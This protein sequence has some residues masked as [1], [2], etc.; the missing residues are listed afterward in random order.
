M[1]SITRRAFTIEICSLPSS[2]HSAGPAAVD[3]VGD[4]M[5]SAIWHS[6]S[7]VSVPG[8]VAGPFSSQKGSFNILHPARQVTDVGCQVIRQDVRCRSNPVHGCLSERRKSQQ[9]G[10]LAQFHYRSKVHR[11]SPADTVA[12][13]QNHAPAVA[14]AAASAASPR[15]NV[16]AASASG[17]QSAPDQCGGFKPRQNRLPSPRRA[18]GCNPAGKTSQ[19]PLAAARRM[20]RNP[21]VRPAAKSAPLSLTPA[22][23]QPGPAKLPR[24]G[25]CMISSR[26]SG[27]EGFN[28]P[29]QQSA[30]PSRCSP[31]VRNCPYRQG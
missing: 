3:G 21:I 1:H 7:R 10:Q 9:Y 25:S 22:P 14:S 19:R 31:P 26:R 13:Q 5:F 30:S 8:Q 16:V 4:R 27:V 2:L 17:D 18:S 12:C 29:S 15:G 20:A 24:R 28:S 11:R 6:L 23:H